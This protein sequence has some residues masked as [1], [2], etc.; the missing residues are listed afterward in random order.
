MLDHHLHVWPH[1]RGTPPPTVQLIEQYC[2]AAAQHGVIEIAITEHCYRFNQIAN[3]VLPH[4]ERPATGA[5]AEATNRILEVESGGDL[6]SYVDVLVQ[7]QDRG[8]PVLV[9]LEVDYLPGA[10]PAMSEL[11]AQYPFDLLLGSVHWLDDWLF[12]AYGI[13]AFAQVWEQRD[14]DQVYAE[15]V[16]AI[17]AL[18]NSG[19]VDAL[20]HLD[21][22]KVAGYMPDQPQVHYTRLVEAL[23][24]CEVAVEFSSA[25]LHKPAA[26][27][28][29]A[30]QI[31]GQLANAGV[32]I[33]TASDA[34]TVEKVGQG[35]DVLRT[36]LTDLGITQ[37]TTFSRREPRLVNV[38][39]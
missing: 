2:E 33:T 5:L 4:W 10:V 38:T 26:A 31:L 35:Y 25:G 3:Q 16:D 13:D 37:L 15:Y 30:P 39:S 27:T 34:H 19:M 14:T 22:I 21:V 29:P 18:A 11:L 28:Y 23:A 9:G 7:A 6:E 8:L 20:A 36:H 17:I 32:G 12:D 24:T 1:E